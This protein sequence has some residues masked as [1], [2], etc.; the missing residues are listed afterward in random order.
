MKVARARSLTLWLL[1][2]TLLWPVWYVG[3]FGSV[4]TAWT[5]A[6]LLAVA[7][8]FSWDTTGGLYEAASV[9]TLSATAASVGFLGTYLLGW[10]RPPRAI[11]IPAAATSLIFQVFVALFWFGMSGSD[12]GARTVAVSFASAIMVGLCVGAGAWLGTRTRRYESPA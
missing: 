7:T 11:W 5:N 12:T 4:L 3:V 1:G 10:L 6:L 9:L 2:V 8:T